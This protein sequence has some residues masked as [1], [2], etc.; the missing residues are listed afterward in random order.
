MQSRETGLQFFSKSPFLGSREPERI[1]FAAHWQSPGI[2][3]RISLYPSQSKTFARIPQEDHQEQGSLSCWTS[4]DCSSEE[5]RA[6]TEPPHAFVGSSRPSRILLTRSHHSPLRWI[7][8]N[9]IVRPACSSPEGQWL[10]TDRKSLDA[11]SSCDLW[12][13]FPNEKERLWS[14]NVSDRRDSTPDQGSLCFFMQET[15]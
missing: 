2:P 10:E 12:P 7:D 13:Y 6:S 1:S 3:W 9:R 8:W 14:I 15:T 5:T 11:S 4:A